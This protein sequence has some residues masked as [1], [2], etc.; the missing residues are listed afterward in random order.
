MG[1]IE[2]GGVSIL[3][4]F[5]AGLLSVASPCVLPMVPRCELIE[6]EGIEGAF[7]DWKILKVS[8]LSFIKPI[9]SIEGQVLSG[10]LT[11]CR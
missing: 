6:I 8:D 3:V 5:V 1:F 4:A 10:T 9:V 11:L 2:I 7:H